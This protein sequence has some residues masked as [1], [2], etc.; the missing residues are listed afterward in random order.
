MIQPL[1]LRA[2]ERR[3]LGGGWDRPA[4]VAALA[5]RHSSEH[6]AAFFLARGV[7][8]SGPRRHDRRAGFAPQVLHE[9]VPPRS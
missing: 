2:V 7:D 3:L 4:A 1:A 5:Q 8:D 9:E 6:F